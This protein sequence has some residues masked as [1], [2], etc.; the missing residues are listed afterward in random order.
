M[1]PAIASPVPSA[2]EARAAHYVPC[3]NNFNPIRTPA[4]LQFSS[5]S[6]PGG[7]MTRMLCFTIWVMLATACRAQ[8][9]RGMA[10]VAIIDHDRGIA[11]TPHFCHGE[12]WVAGTPGAHYAIEI[13]NRLGERLLAVTSVD[14]INVISGATAGWDQTGYVFRA[15]DQYQVSGWRKSD[16][17]V[18]AFTFADWSNSYAVRTGRPANIGIIGIAIFRERRAEPLYSP[19]RQTGHT[20]ESAARAP[21]TAAAAAAAPKLGTAHGE[22]EY[23]Y[24]NQT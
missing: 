15:G 19:Q 9:V 22:R 17:E 8:G 4:S 14:G 18:A 12:Y 23:S 5:G 1:R 24:V 10:D 6:I 11:L 20:A 7:D 16:A 21:T 3:I 13:R 2:T